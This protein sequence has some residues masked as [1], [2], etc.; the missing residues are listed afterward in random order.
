MIHSTRFWPL[1]INIHSIWH[2]LWDFDHCEFIY[3]PYETFY[4]IL[5]LV[6]F[7]YMAMALD[8][9]RYFF[10]KVYTMDALF[11]PLHTTPFRYMTICFG[12]LHKHSANITIFL[13]SILNATPILYVKIYFGASHSAD[14]TK[15][16]DI[17]TCD[18]PTWFKTATSSDRGVLSLL[19]CSV[20]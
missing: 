16:D 11:T 18:I 19:I 7:I 12:I 9:Y 4:E 5:T 10:C 20:H 13:L 2:V 6:N 3:I 17:P 8:S 1:W 15:S 14:G